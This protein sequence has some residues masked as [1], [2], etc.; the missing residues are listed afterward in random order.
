MLY[1]PELR[2]R[3]EVTGAGAFRFLLDNADRLQVRVSGRPVQP[4]NP[5]H[6]LDHTSSLRI[7]SA[8]AGASGVLEAARL[9]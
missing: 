3:G 9:L 2:A 5:W 1:P 8:V 7:I 6:R 4:R